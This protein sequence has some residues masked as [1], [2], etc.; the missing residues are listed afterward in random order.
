MTFNERLSVLGKMDEWDVA[1][2]AGDREAMMRILTELCLTQ[3]EAVRTIDA[4]LKK[5]QDR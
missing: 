4:L 2:F 1:R 5:M 3:E